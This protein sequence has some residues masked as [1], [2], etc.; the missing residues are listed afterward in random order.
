MDTIASIATAV[1]AGGIAVIR[2]S[3]PEAKSVLS[4]VFAPH[5]PQKMSSRMLTYGY[6]MENGQKVDECMAVWMRAPHTYTT[7]DVA[8]IQCH[9]G[10]VTA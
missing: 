3:G 6:V 9:G 2:I 4:R 10:Q 7:E 8:E 1:G 5:V